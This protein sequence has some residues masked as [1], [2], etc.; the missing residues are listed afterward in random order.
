MEEGFSR[1]ALIYAVTGI[2]FLAVVGR[3]W[4]FLSWG[5]LPRWQKIAMPMLLASPILAVGASPLAGMVV[6]VVFSWSTAV[7]FM[8]TASKG[9][10]KDPVAAWWI[11]L[12]GCLLLFASN[13][14]ESR[15]WILPLNSSA[16]TGACIV[17]IY[18]GRKRGRA[19]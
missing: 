8:E 5:T 7:A 18:A 9:Y 11:E 10:S 14:W 2:L 1:Q 12:A 19:S 3:R 16:V 4:N 13:G 15:S 6:Q 17:A